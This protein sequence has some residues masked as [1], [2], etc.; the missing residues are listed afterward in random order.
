MARAL[1]STS[2]RDIGTPDRAASSY[3]IRC[4]TSDGEPSPNGGRPVAANRS[5]DAQA[6]TSVAGPMPV[7]LSCSGDR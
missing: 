7:P 5:V 3:M 4:I 2:R 1:V 6:N